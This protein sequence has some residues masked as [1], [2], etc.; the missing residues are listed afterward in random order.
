MI[1]RDFPTH[2]P[3]RDSRNLII[4]ARGAD[5]AYPEHAGPLSIKCVFQGREIYEVNGA[6]HAVDEASY[7]L[8]NNGQRYSCH[9]P[10]EREVEVFTVFFNPGF[11]EEVL[12]SLITP[13]DRLLNEPDHA[14][15]Q[16]VYFFERL[17]PLDAWSGPWSAGSAPRSAAGAPARDGPIVAEGGAVTSIDPPEAFVQQGGG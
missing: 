1:P 4:V 16:P 10:S 2:L 14:C 6:R 17:Y 3:A 13:A 11:A 12:R 5:V 9:I 15:E 7:L 8:L